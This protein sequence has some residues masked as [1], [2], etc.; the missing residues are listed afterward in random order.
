ME[1]SRIKIQISGIQ[2][3]V[4]PSMAPMGSCQ[5]MV[6]LR[7]WD[8]ALRPIKRK[9]TLY[10]ATA[11]TFV[12][13]LPGIDP[14]T[15]LPPVPPVSYTLTLN[16]SEGGTTDV[17]GSTYSNV[18]TFAENSNVFLVARPLAGYSF[19]EYTGDLEST[20]IVEHIVM[21]ENKVINVTF[22]DAYIQIWDT[23]ET[24]QLP[25]IQLDDDSW[26]EDDIYHVIIKA[27]KSG[28]YI[29]SLSYS[30]PGTGWIDMVDYYNE[31]IGSYLFVGIGWGS[32]IADNVGV[33]IHMIKPPAPGTYQANIRFETPEGFSMIFLI[34]LSL[35]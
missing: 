27:P 10:T 20:N 24:E 21:T 5:D 31:E 23:E 14:E 15:G 26:P 12:P 13:P 9:K 11:G 16:V 6:N 34:E 2:R 1:P 18:I 29:E 4:S 28:W 8:G 32:P 35:I 19:V 7:I 30:G 22:T 33:R 3:D 17:N 25:W